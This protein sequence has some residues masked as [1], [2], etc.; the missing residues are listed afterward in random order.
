[1]EYFME[2][3]ACRMYDVKNN[4]VYSART[5]KF[6]EQE[7]GSKLLK[8]KQLTEQEKNDQRASDNEDYVILYLENEDEGNQDIREES[9][10]LETINEN[11]ESEDLENENRETMNPQEEK[12][13]RKGAR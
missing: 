2:S 6:N 1:M 8:N 5:V 11:L 4:R 3:R 9:Q 13:K 12:K 10:T 7:R